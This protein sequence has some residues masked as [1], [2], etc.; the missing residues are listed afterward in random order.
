MRVA[1]AIVGWFKAIVCAVAFITSLGAARLVFAGELFD[2]ND[3]VL[4]RYLAW[5]SLFAAVVNLGAARQAEPN[6]SLLK[7][8]L[9]FFG[10]SAVSPVVNLMVTGHLLW[11][12]WVAMLPDLA[13]TLVSTWGL[14]GAGSSHPR[15]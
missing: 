2:S 13:M 5:F 12:W 6:R 9:V 7:L 15:P 1:L 14:I 8:N 11:I 10:L 4:L 3:L